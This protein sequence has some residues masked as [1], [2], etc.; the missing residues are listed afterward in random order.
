[1]T[2]DPPALVS[3][4]IACYNQGRFLGEAIDS[5]LRQTHAPIEVIVVDDGSSDRTADVAAAYPVRCLRQRNQGAPAARNHGFSHSQGRYVLFLDAD[6]RL[7]PEAVA[8][9]CAA[10]AG[11]PDWAFVTGHVRLIASDGAAEGTP[12]QEHAGGDQFLA[13]L[14][15]NYIWTPGAVLYRRDVLEGGPFDPSA[16]ASAD[17]ELNLR[18]A[19]RHPVG[20]HHEVVLEYRRHGANMSADAGDMLRSAMTVRLR[21]RPIVTG[22]AAAER[23]WKEGIAIVRSDFGERLR[24]QVRQ[25]LRRP[26]RWPRAALGL[27]RL[28]RY[29]PGGLWRGF[30]V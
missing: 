27:A 11:H 7:L 2:S 18:L 9:G 5:A 4:V 20:C 10:L 28:A 14:R 13:L 6:D 1:M 26:A 8:T 25:D 15:S 19:R 16:K 30:A 24:R 12:P 22:N 23:S 3:I 21:Q 17:Y 29:Y